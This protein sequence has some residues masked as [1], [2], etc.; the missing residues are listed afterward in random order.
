MTAIVVFL[1]FVSIQAAASI[2]AVVVSNPE[3]FAAGTPLEQLQS[4]PVA[5]GLSLLAFEGLLCVLL[6]LWFYLALPRLR[7]EWVSNF[8]QAD[9]PEASSRPRVRRVL[10]AV[11]SVTLFSFGLSLLLHPLH[12]SDE[13]TTGMFRSMLAHPLCLLQLVVV[14]PLAEELVF[15]RGIVHSLHRRGLP[16][17]AAATVGAFAFALVHGNLAQAVPALL[18]GFL[19]GMLYLRTNN[20][21]L[22]LPAHMANNLLAVAFLL[23]PDALSFADRWPVAAVLALGLLH[24]G[25]GVLNMRRALH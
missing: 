6:G 4:D 7:G 18:A 25:L 2:L 1:L 10:F 16:G 13:G 19:L 9:L 3:A 14:G 22:C 8:V 12:L 21:W 5:L 24:V 17:W 20:L 11:L 15:R 23:R